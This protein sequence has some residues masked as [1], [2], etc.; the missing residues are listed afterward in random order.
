MAADFSSIS[1]LI[2]AHQ[3]ELALPGVLSVR[4]GY[5]FHEGWITDTPA[6]VVTVTTTVSGLP[7]EIEGVPVDVRVASPRKTLQVQDP[8]AYARQVGPAPDYGAV[9]E[10]ADEWR[11]DRGAVARFVPLQTIARPLAAKPELDYTAPAGASLAPVTLT[12]STSITL[13]AS[14]DSGWPT[15]SAFLTDTKTSLTVGMY[16]FT[17]AHVLQTVEKV[18]VGKTVTMV[19]DHPSKN[20]TADQT[21]EQTV[22]SLVTAFGDDLSQAWALER[23][24]P[25]AAAWIFPTAYHIKVAVRDSSSVWVSSGNWNNSNQPDIDPVTTPGDATAARSGDRDWHV[26]I[27][28]AGL[29][30]TFEAFLLNDLAVASAHDVAGAA[31]ADATSGPVSEFIDEPAL[32]PLAETPPFAQFFASTVVTD[33]TRV[34]PVLTPDAGVYVGAVT[35]LIESATSTL[36]MQFQ[37]IELPKVSS[38][39][40]A[41]LE[42]L[43]AAIVARQKAGVDVKIIM[44]E[45]ETAGFLEKLQAAGLAVTTSVKIQNNV[46]NKGVVVD[47]ARVLVSSQNWSSAGVTTNRDAG[48][49]LES[50]AAAHYF[51]EIFEHDWEHLAAPTAAID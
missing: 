29:A 11:V 22:A 43:V 20:P 19:L 17:S 31:H 40:S 9:P 45:Y 12:P 10:F 49:V 38:V 24:D 21:D 3:T 46:H 36:H 27:D 6:V 5:A 42:A 23:M 34:T 13:S 8:A 50:T 51:D 16:D 25:E 15:L 1:D 32:L 33:T 26:V 48:V 44:S 2:R 37:Y 7:D 28:D 14:P 35:S 30:A 47:G 18:L 39:A 4:P 41:P